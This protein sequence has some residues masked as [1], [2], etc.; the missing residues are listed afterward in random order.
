[1]VYSLKCE[2]PPCLSA[3][4]KCIWWTQRKGRLIPVVLNVF[5]YL[6]MLA[7]V[8][9]RPVRPVGV[10]AC[11]CVKRAATPNRCNERQTWLRVKNV[12]TESRFTFTR[13]GSWEDKRPLNSSV[14]SVGPLS[15]EA[16]WNWVTRVLMAFSRSENW[17]GNTRGEAQSYSGLIPSS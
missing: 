6:C 1:M 7:G 9:L 15:A 8:C 11:L 5:V 3:K 4:L 17:R 12:D 13:L 14:L 16:E 2:H 10:W